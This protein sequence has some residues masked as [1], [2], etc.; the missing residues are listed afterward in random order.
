MTDVGT[1]RVLLADDHPVYL[2]GLRMLLDTLPGLTVVGV[3]ADGF[4]L[5]ELAS[6]VSADVAVVDIDMPGLDGADAAHRILATR[7]ELGVLVLT[8][9]DEEATVVRA[10]RAGARGYV[11]KSAEPDAIGRAIAAVAGGDTWFTG[12]VGDRVRAAAT[13]GHRHG[14]LGELSARETEVLDLVSRGLDNHA[15]ARRLFLS[16]KTI[17]NHVSAILGK[18][19]VTS[20]AEAVARARD[21]GFGQ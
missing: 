15:I 1:I 13:R 11:L 6:T 9:H 12:A 14:P 5:V 10:L 8:M 19:A 3:A 7:P 20:R 4:A 18:L 17:Q 2:A 21:A 16:P